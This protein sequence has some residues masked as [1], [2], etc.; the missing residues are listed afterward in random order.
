MRIFL[1][2][3]ILLLL[4]K[5]IIDKQIYRAEISSQVMQ[6]S[7]WKHSFEDLFE[8]H[9]SNNIKDLAYRIQRYPIPIQ[10]RAK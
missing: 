6:V 7:F 3:I 10:R 1:S 5:N 4:L 9:C 8:Q 2:C